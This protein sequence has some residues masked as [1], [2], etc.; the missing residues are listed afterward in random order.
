MNQAISTSLL[1]PPQVLL[2]G[3]AL[4]ALMMDAQEMLGRR[5]DVVTEAALY[6]ML[7]EQVPREAQPL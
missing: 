3:F 4:G 7:Q 5:V 2:S 1:M 6:P